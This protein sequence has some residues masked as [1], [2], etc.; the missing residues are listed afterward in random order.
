MRIPVTLSIVL[1]AGA[2][3]AMAQN[4]S[5]QGTSE[6]AQTSGTSTLTG[7]LHGSKNQYYVMEKNGTNHVLLTR[8]RDLSKYLN[9][10][11][12]VTGKA[13]TNRDASASSD[14]GTA[15]GNRFF[16]LESISD[17]GACKK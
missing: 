11:V 14:E 9:H 10:Q 17:Q 6:P 4:P 16:S 5:T 15:H 2:L 13:D 12:T 8:E 3:L 7:C 1:C